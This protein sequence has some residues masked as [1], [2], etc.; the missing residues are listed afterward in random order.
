M[1]PV[2]KENTLIKTI[3]YVNGRHH[4]AG[5]CAKVQ[6]SVRKCCMDARKNGGRRCV[7]ELTMSKDPRGDPALQTAGTCCVLDRE[8]GDLDTFEDD[9]RRSDLETV[10]L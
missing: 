4:D 5:A 8:P 7:V 6:V 10:D 3:A 1:I 2:V 9:E